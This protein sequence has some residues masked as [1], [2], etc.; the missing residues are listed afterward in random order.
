V[1]AGESIEDAGFHRAGRR[2]K[3]LFRAAFAAPQQDGQI[4]AVA[5]FARDV[6]EV[7]IARRKTEELLAA[8]QQ[9]AAALRATQE[10]MAKNQVET[11]HILQRL[12]LVTQTSTEGLWDMTVPD[13]MVFQDDTPFWWADRFRQ[14]VGYT[15]EQDFPNRLDSWA[16]LLH[17]DHKAPTLEAF[18]AHLVDL[19]GQTPYDVE[20]QLKLKN[21]HTAGSG[22]WART[23][24]DENG[25]PLRV[26]GSLIDIQALKELE[27]LP[28]RTG[29][30]GAGKNRRDRRIA[31]L[32]PDSNGTTG[33]R[34]GGMQ[35]ILLESQRQEQYLNELINSSKDSIFT[36]DR[37]FKL[38]SFNNTLRAT[39]LNFGITLEK[40]T[41]MLQILDGAERAKLTDNKPGLSTGRT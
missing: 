21:G 32:F 28:T 7:T 35:N 13:N 38:I 33:G 34:P 37:D 27:L 2:P 8:S 24:R 26:A 40:G 23:V 1:F 18:N 41:D 15:N 22:P 39:Y 10:E 30:K 11:A 16:N 31:G 25:K 12:N 6:T 14:M 17:P 20:Y 3:T 36:V 4:I 9:Q 29:S 5:I 19:S